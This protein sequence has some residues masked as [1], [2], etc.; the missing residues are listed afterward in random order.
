MPWLFYP[1]G[2]IFV[3]RLLCC[4]HAYQF[5]SSAFQLQLLETLPTFTL[6]QSQV[7]AGE[8]LTCYEHRSLCGVPGSVARHALALCWPPAARLSGACAGISSDEILPAPG[9]RGACISAESKCK[10]WSPWNSCHPH[11]HHRTWRQEKR[12]KYKE[13][14]TDFF[15]FKGTLTCLFNRIVKLASI[16]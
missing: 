12:N 15:F 14:L 9:G 7:T 10:V 3:P 4:E 8:A 13:T 5:Q 11:C 2:S 16:F 6:P 1:D